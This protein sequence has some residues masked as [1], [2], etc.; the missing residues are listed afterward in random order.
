L[1]GRPVETGN[2]VDERHDLGALEIE[3]STPFPYQVDGDYLGETRR[4]RF[5]HRPAV[6][7]LVL[8]LGRTGT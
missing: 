8:P 7:D 3:A 1:R 4:L 5:E 6:L 2:A